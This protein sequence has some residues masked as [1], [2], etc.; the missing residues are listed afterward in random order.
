MR[1]KVVHWT[2]GYTILLQISLMH[3]GTQ[4]G[5]NFKQKL[6]CFLF[7]CGVYKWSRLLYRQDFKEAI[8][9]MNESYML[10]I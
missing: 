6:L 1:C 7:P 2:C 3:G 5:D 9:A 8:F 4:I 10:K